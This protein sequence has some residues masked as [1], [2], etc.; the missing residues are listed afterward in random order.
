VQLNPANF[1]S[2]N[3]EMKIFAYIKNNYVYPEK[4]ISKQKSLATQ[5]KMILFFNLP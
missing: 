3:K 4:I 5:E 1:S 2:T